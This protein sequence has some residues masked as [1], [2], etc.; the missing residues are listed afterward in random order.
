MQPTDAQ[1]EAGA[2]AWFT[3]NNTSGSDAD[4]AMVSQRWPGYSDVQKDFYRKMTRI[5]LVAALAVTS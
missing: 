3:A 1:V 5:V 2:I 4:I